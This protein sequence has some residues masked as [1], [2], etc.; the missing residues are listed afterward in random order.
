MTLWESRTTPKSHGFTIVELLIVVIVIGILASISIVAYTGVQSRAKDSVVSSN[1]AQVT[2]ALE[3]YYQ[4][5]NSYPKSA[6]WGRNG[7]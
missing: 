2:K 1:I 6:E 5:T 3:I 7:P 4:R